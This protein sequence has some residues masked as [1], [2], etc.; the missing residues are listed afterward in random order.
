LTLIAATAGFDTLLRVVGP[1]Q[2]AW[3]KQQAE[4]QAKEQDCGQQE[5]NRRR[6]ALQPKLFLRRHCPVQLC[7]PPGPRE[8]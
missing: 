3:D 7:P 8:Q 4:E 5:E 1:A 6:P 2:P